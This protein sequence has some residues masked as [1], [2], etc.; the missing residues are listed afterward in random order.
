MSKPTWSNTFGC[1]AT[2]AFFVLGVLGPSQ[3]SGKIAMHT[4]YLSP[5]MRQ[6]RDQQVRFAPYEKQIQQAESA[7]RL[8]NELDPKRTYTCKYICHQVTNNGYESDPDLKFTGK[9]ARHDLLLF[10]EDLS[11]AARVPASAVGERVLTIDELASQ[12]RVSRK[13]VSRWRRQG[14]VCRRFLFDG[15]Q[16]IGFL[17]SS[18][19]R[20]AA[21][22]EK[23]I[24]RGTE[25][26]PLT[27]EDRKQLIERARSL[28]QAGAV[29][30][31]V[32]KRTVQ[33]TGRSKGTVRSTPKHFDL[34][35]PD[36]AIIPC[37]QGPLRI[38]AK[39]EVYQQYCRGDSVQALAQRFCR[40]PSRIYR[41]IN[42]MR[43]HGSW[44]CRWTTSATNSS[45]AC[46][47]KKRKR[48]FWGRCRKA[49]CRQSSRGCPAVCPRIWQAYTRCLY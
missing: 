36:I 17:Q 11:D 12:F 21:L 14:L 20:F 18:V 37:N 15:H 34:E 19:D 45:P 29:P 4:D 41:I 46:A 49:I 28:A 48:R 5:A 35:H 23:R 2:S 16:Q 26:S 47:R 32:T 30:A 43:T 10:I 24:R 8:L 42:E 39:Q 22:N 1:S 9:V 3:L 13:T 6:F 44:S 40:A 27:D 7:E 38:E 31:M 33:E 25:F